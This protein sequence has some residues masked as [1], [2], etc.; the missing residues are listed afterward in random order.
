MRWLKTKSIK[1]RMMIVAMINGLLIFGSV[2][3][4]AKAIER[5][6]DDALLVNLAGR[7]RMLTQRMAKSCFALSSDN[8]NPTESEMMLGILKESKNLYDD[9]LHMFLEGGMTELNGVVVSTPQVTKH[10][11]TIAILHDIWIDCQKAIDAI[12]EGEEKQER[13]T[14]T[15]RDAVDKIIAKNEMFL[16]KTDEIVT[17]L[18]RDAE[19]HI[20]LVK[21]QMILIVILEI[22]VLLVFMRSIDIGILNPFKRLFGALESVGKGEHYTPS[23]TEIYLEWI[24]TEQLI[25]EMSEKLIGAKEELSKLN[26]ELEEKVILRTADLNATIEKLEVTYKKLLESEKQASLGA[27]VAGVAHEINTPLGV[28]LTGSTQLR[29]ESEQ[30]LYKI[31]NNQMT[32]EDLKEYLSVNHD[33]INILEFNINRAADII[34]SFKKIAIHQSTEIVETFYLDEY[35]NDLWVSIGHVTKKY[36]VTFENH[37]A[38]ERIYGNP[39]DYSQIF[40]NLFMN[41]FTHAYKVGER[42]KITVESFKNEEGLI[43]KYKDYGKGISASSIHKIF[44]PFYTTNRAGGGSGLGLNVIFQIIVNK[45]GGEITCSSDIGKHT[46]FTI[47]ITKFEEEDYV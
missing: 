23:H 28:C 2:F 20:V 25:C 32:K 38:H 27:L 18:Q 36:E 37:L 40:T 35:I 19:N 10:Q 8:L 42:A 9:T 39:G 14:P 26:H 17:L 15:Y 21:Q 5:Q 29:S 13:D 45:L 30:L 22:V 4:L 46:E 12:I 34:R 11:D 44:D 33:L 6:N 24:Q 43:I 1:R 16:W 47:K 31:R 7:Q 3:F 41:T